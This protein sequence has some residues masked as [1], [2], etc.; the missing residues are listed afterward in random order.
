MSKSVKFLF[1]CLLLLL[2]TG[3]AQA[4]PGQA[5]KSAAPQAAVQANDLISGAVVETMDAAGY[6]YLCLESNGQKSWAA[7]PASQVKVG[8]EVSISNGMVMRNFTSKTLARTFDAI[9]FSSGI[10]AR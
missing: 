2:V 6:T 1:F 4:F 3:Q 10:V 5:A 8:E 7:I 9:I